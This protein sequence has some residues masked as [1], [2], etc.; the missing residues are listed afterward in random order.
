MCYL[1]YISVP[2]TFFQALFWVRCRALA[3]RSL[4]LITCTA[5]VECVY[6]ELFGIVGKDGVVNEN[7]AT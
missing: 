7:T 6:A 5:I 4:L 1:G 2:G 3:V